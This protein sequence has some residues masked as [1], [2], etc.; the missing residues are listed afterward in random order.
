MDADAP[1]SGSSPSSQAVT[2]A[3]L[4]R[5]QQEAGPGKTSAPGGS[6]PATRQSGAGDGRGARFIFS[7]SLMGSL[8][9]VEIFNLQ[10]L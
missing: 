6:V 10:H 1:G 2:R 9:A 3:A 4:G 7:H 5:V 8:Q